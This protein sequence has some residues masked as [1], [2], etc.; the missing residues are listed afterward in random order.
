MLKSLYVLVRSETV[1]FSRVLF[2]LFFLSKN[3]VIPDKI[4][5]VQRKQVPTPMNIAPPRL[6][7]PRQIENT[8]EPKANMVVILV[9]KIA[10]PVLAKILFTF[11]LPSNCLLYTSDAADEED[12][13]DLGGR[14]IIKN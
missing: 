5:T 1:K 7:N 13:V 9:K 3:P 11:P 8:K 12:S 10:F 4:I 14:R 6:P 2:Y